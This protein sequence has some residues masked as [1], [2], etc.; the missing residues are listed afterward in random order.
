MYQPDLPEV[1]PNWI[2]GCEV[3]SSAGE[4]FGKLS[5]ATGKELCRVVRSRSADVAQGIEAA[6]KAFP[7]W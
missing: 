4:T 6:M 5:P 7:A 2:D 3:E 1:I